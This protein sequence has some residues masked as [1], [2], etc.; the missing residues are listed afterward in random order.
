MGQKREEAR[1][2]KE[3]S[4][5][6]K[7]RDDLKN[8]GVEL[9]D[10]EKMWRAKGGMSGV[11]IGYR[12]SAGPTDLEICTLVVQ[13]EKA[14]QS[15]DFGT[16]DMIRDELKKVGVEVSDKEK[17]WRVTDGRGGRVPSWDT[18]VDGSRADSGQFQITTSL[19]HSIPRHDTQQVG[20][21]STFDLQ[22]QI[23]QAALANSQNPATAV[24]TLQLLQQ[25][26]TECQLVSKPQWGGLTTCEP[27]PDPELEEA[28]NFCNQCKASGH[29]V[30]DTE[31]M[32]LVKLREKFRQSKDFASADR[33]R[34]SM[35]NSLGVELF[36]KEKRWSLND[37]RQGSIPLWNSIV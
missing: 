17:V 9:F 14:R 16:A 4:E 37:G 7:I 28:L 25:A 18:L 32:W 35:K 20:L 33:L 15:G 26:A 30:A 29:Y 2:A 27:K 36:E 34:N 13:R 11:I 5:S 8:M 23:V 19:Q 21:S 24:R 1:A 6:D 22:N 31:I 10:K 3:W 12:G